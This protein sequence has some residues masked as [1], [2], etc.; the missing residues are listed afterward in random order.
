MQGLT[1]GQVVI[2][3]GT[4]DNHLHSSKGIFLKEL[5]HA[6]FEGNGFPFMER[7]HSHLWAMTEEK[8]H[9]SG[10]TEKPGRITRGALECWAATDGLVKRSLALQ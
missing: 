7:V 3:H 9:A 6:A 4:R 8:R 5:G 1:D 2:S 10:R